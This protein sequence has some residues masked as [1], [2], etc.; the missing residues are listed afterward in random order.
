MLGDTICWC[1]CDM[2]VRCVTSFLWCGVVTGGRRTEDVGDK[3][4]F[5]KME[6]GEWPAY[7][8]LCDYHPLHFACTGLG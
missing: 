2:I 1:W 3:T 6:F 5:E 8:V 7:T 4:V